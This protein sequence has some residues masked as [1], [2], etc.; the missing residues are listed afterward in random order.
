MVT[1][2]VR[3]RV[4]DYEAWKVMYEEHGAVRKEHGSTGATVLRDASDP[5][6]VL[7]LTYWPALAN[8]QAFASDPS[9]AEAMQRAGVVS[10]PRIEFYE[11]AG[12]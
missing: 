9:L 8:A 6:E 3:H 10:E 4:G 2:A 7:V 12:V 1:V 5:A 11:E